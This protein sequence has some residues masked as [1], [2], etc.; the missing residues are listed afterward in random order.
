MH[1]NKKNFII[2]AS[3]LILIGVSV[4]VTQ[5]YMLYRTFLDEQGRRLHELVQSQASLASEFF[6]HHDEDRLGVIYDFDSVI[7]RLAKAQK[8]FEVESKSGEFTT[9]IKTDN[10]IN[11]LVVDG[12]R[13]LTGDPLSQLGLDSNHAIPMQNAL[14]GKT[15]TIIAK[16]YRGKIVL[17]AFTPVKNLKKDIGMVA[18]ID[19]SEI[20]RPFFVVTVEVFLVGAILITMGVILL[21]FFSDPFFKKLEKSEKEYRE[22]VEN[23]NSFI[24]RV[25]KDGII[26]FANSF[27]QKH[28]KLTKT[29][30]VGLP[31]LS[32]L[33]DTPDSEIATNSIQ[34]V[35][36]FFGEGIGPHEHPFIDENGSVIWIAWRIKVNK[37]LDG[38]PSNILCI[39]NDI[40]AKYNTLE[41]L[42]DSE[43]RYRNIFENAPLAMVHF[44]TQ[45]KISDCNNIFLDLMGSNRSKVIGFHTSEDSQPGM[46]QA[47]KKALQGKY[48]VFEDIYTSVTGNKTLFLRAVFNPVIKH[49]PPYE[50]IAT[51]EDIT[52]RKKV[53]IDLAESE[54]RFKG[55]AKASPVG[56]IITDLTGKV[57]YA[58]ERMLQICDVHYRELKTKGWTAS[59][60]PEDRDTIEYNWYK[61][62]PT[63]TDRLEFRIIRDNGQPLWVL[64]QLVGLDNSN[65]EMSG[66]ITTV[67][68]ITNVKETELEHKRLITAIDQAAEA[69]VITETSGTIVYV[70]PAFERITGYSVE[71]AIGNNPSILKSGEHDDS[72]YTDLWNT[73]NQGQTWKGHFINLAKDGRR[74]TQEATI[75]PVRNEEG[76]IVSFVCVARDI[77]NQL[78]VE[79]QL[80][81]A[82]KLESIGELAAGIAHEINTPTQ[83]VTTNMK[84]LSDSFTELINSLK[85]VSSIRQTINEN[86]PTGTI[87]DA[88]AKLIDDS[89]IAF[90]EEDIPNAIKE[91]E[92]GLNRISE[93]VKSVKQLAHP[94]ETQKN[95]YNL[96]E[97]INDAI[98]V[99]ANEWK[100]VATIRKNLQEDLPKV[101][102]LKGEMGQVILNLIVNSAHGIESKNAATKEK[103]II[104]ISSYLSDEQAVIEITDTGCGMPPQ[105]I[106]RA[107]DPFF[108][109][110]QVGKGTGQG[111]A[112]AHNVIVNIHNGR[113]SIDSIENE[114]S[115]I[116][117]RLP[118]NAPETGKA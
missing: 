118:I 1:K 68:D 76:K 104:T 21:Y 32:I 85:Q 40:T 9:A 55:I 112:I 3:I 41:Q 2:L 80:R 82:Q 74:Y 84:F 109:T 27:A 107:F 61:N 44:D 47:L 102:C 49:N 53:E 62:V 5:S 101:S 4:S 52:E 69:I 81:Q 46:R 70:N 15:G 8:Q 30:L 98:T 59:I 38:S 77:S 114:G 71:E 75:D 116:T 34:K 100:Y 115:T 65:N 111:L 37:N 73:I 117:V 99:S 22:L 18:K 95:Y 23:A 72:F 86:S 48:S 83:Y 88:M 57:K 90:L 42:K 58:N 87:N 103:G 31:L 64:G 94:G 79:A 11:F 36:S 66:Y 45:G 16:D 78:M 29:K 26:S 7:E 39:G 91:S 25:N 96:N 108:T 13:V 24:L 51:L 89:E 35:I 60:H 105:I 63:T 92:E 6:S 97:I 28:F 10:A 50:V 110:K 113:I 33:T 20:Q 54:Q 12:R 43:S 14:A 19:L 106:E 67:T 93:I 17:A 56:I